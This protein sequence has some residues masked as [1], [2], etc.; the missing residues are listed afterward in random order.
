VTLRSLALTKLLRERWG[1]G[2]ALTRLVRERW[3]DGS[4]GRE[5]RPVPPVLIGGRLA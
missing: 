1:E 4:V 5:V 2:V 3:I